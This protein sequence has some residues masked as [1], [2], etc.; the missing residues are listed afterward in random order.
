MTE[1]LLRRSQHALERLKDPQDLS[2]SKAPK[3]SVE[4]LKAELTSRLGYAKREW[5]AIED[6]RNA[7]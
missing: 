1:Y 2:G 5:Q 4:F 6:I 3:D 7:K